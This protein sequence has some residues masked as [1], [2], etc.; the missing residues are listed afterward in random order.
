M[1]SYSPK[2]PLVLDKV[3]GSYSTNKSILDV[4]KQN[5]KMLLLTNPGERV[6]DPNFGVGM[7]KFIFY[8]DNDKLRN[9]IRQKIVDQTK[10]YLNFIVISEILISP[11]NSNDN[12]TLYVSIKYFING[13]NTG[14][15]LNLAIN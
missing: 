12:N 8:Q 2:L 4:V 6:M 13:L 10:K 11:V 15:I 7:R 1:S 5:F 14:D 3:D 9:D